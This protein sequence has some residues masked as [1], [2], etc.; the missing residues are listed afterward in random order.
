MH[1]G[2][3]K[4]KKMCFNVQ[5][6]SLYD[7]PKHTIKTG[8]EIVL[9]TI[10]QVADRFQVSKQTVRRRIKDGSLKA[11]KL[12]YNTVRVEES[13]LENY[14]RAAQRKEEP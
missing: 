12:G 10:E 2:A 1:T 7:L 6:V 8:G 11:I 13:E 9:L 4:I 3:H 5:L 14:I